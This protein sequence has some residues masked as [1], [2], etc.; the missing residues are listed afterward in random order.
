MFFEAA[1]FSV[2][3]AL[4]GFVEQFLSLCRV[5][6]ADLFDQVGNLGHRFDPVGVDGICGK[7]WQI[8][9]AL[10]FLEAIGQTLVGLKCRVGEVW[11]DA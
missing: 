9:N 11:A 2:I 7:G 3:D 4:H 6:V 1:T 5:M 10:V 8:T